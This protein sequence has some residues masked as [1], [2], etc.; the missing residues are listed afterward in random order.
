MD[1][2]TVKKNVQKGA[3]VV[4]EKVSMYSRIGRLKMDQLI[5][6][7]KI[8]KNYT[9]AGLSVYEFIKGGKG[10]SIPFSLINEFIEEIDGAKKE[11]E[12]LDKEIAKIKDDGKAKSKNSSTAD[13]D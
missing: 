4:V 2:D 12:D 5:L 11:I 1:L 9:S 6:E 3:G 8:D 7:R 10:E 13:N